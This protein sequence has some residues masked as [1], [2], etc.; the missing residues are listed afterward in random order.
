MKTTL[1]SIV[2]IIVIVGVVFYIFSWQKIPDSPAAPETTVTPPSAEPIASD[3]INLKLGGSSYLDPESRFNF[4]YP[5]DY[6]LD[7]QNNQYV[8]IA[9]TGATQKGQTELYDGVIMV[10]EPINLE[11]QTLEQ[12]VDKYLEAATI[13]GTTQIIETKKPTTFNGYPGFT[14]ATRGLGESKFLVIQKDLNSK[15]ALSIVS[16]VYDPENKNYQKEVDAV[17]TNIQLLK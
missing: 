7:I 8:R 2:S 15:H 13:D 9:K 14:F 10:F 11:N 6:K 17:M 12:W 4:I 16:G 5:N 3:P 1:I